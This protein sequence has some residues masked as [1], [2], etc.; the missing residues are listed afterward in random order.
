MPF[1]SGEIFSLDLASTKYRG[2]EMC[3]TSPCVFRFDTLPREENHVSQKCS[4]GNSAFQQPL[5]RTFSGWL[6]LFKP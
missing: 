6:Q 1:K 2:C 3:L 5:D 4:A